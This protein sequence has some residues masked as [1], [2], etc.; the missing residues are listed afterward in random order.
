MKTKI[1]NA[2]KT[3]Y[4]HLGL[5]DEILQEH[6]GALASLGLVTDDNLSAVVTAQSDYLSKL[7]KLND[8][9]VTDA[10]DKLKKEQEEAAA[11][12]AAEEAEA[13]K[14]AEEEAKAKQEAEEKAKAEEEAK[15]A[16]EE[17]AARKAEEMKKN[18]LIPEE[19]KKIL[20]AN[21]AEAKAREDAFKAQ[22]DAL[23]EQ[24]KKLQESN[25]ALSEGYEKI[26]TEN[27]AV[28]K[29][30][31]EAARKEFILTEA[32]RLNIPQYRI[33]E[34]FVLGSELDNAGITAK[35]TEI[36]NNIKNNQM[37]SRPIPFKQASEASKE[38][39]D[40]IADVLVR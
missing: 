32:K 4:A 8:K 26:K 18:Q 13:K 3:S 20:E 37:P 17:E 12:K 40:N 39:M 10:V 11:K 19:V 31:A 7:Q 34:G 16:A 33:D 23:M 25:T 38:E 21:A 35:L 6:A 22:H 28:K 36:S 9:R 1:F 30:Q 24:L 14:K 2:L 5:G 29:A 27:E 15:K